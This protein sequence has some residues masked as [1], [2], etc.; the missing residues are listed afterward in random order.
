M[1]DKTFALLVVIF[2]AALVAVLL[3]IYYGQG[4]VGAYFLYAS[5]S[6]GIVI[7][8]ETFRRARRQP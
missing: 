7:S 8:L 5:C 2:I 3:L 6:V 1:K 4:K